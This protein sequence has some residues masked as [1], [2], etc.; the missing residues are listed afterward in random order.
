MVEGD[1][2]WDAFLP[3]WS[4]R[5]GLGCDTLKFCI[6]SGRWACCGQGISVRCSDASVPVMDESAEDGSMS[7]MGP[8]VIGLTITGVLMPGMYLA[9]NSCSRSVI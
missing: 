8:P 9:P 2:E 3:V 5:S 7:D 1:R 4:T 6:M